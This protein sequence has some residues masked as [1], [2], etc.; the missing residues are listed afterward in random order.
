MAQTMTGVSRLL[1]KAGKMPFMVRDMDGVET[2]ANAVLADRIAPVIK[3]SSVTGEVCICLR[4]GVSS[5]VPPS[6]KFICADPY[7]Q[8][9]DCIRGLLASLK[10]R[11]AA[12]Y[13]SGLAS[14]DEAA[15]LVSGFRTKDETATT[16]TATTT[17]AA[18]AAPDAP[19]TATATATAPGTTGAGA[20]A[21]AGTSANE[22]GIPSWFDGVVFAVAD[23]GLRDAVGGGLK[24]GGLAFMQSRR[25]AVV[26]IQTAR[27]HPQ[28]V[29]VPPRLLRQRALQLHPRQ[30]LVCATYAGARIFPFFWLLHSSDLP[31]L[32]T[33]A[34]LCCRVASC[35]LGPHRQRVQRAGCRHGRRRHGRARRG[36]GG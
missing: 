25:V 5:H 24:S 20:G 1:R 33:H 12:A 13:G 30:R 31:P 6:P 34:T 27:L 22:C 32:L 23:A 26:A 19:A 2:A 10:P 29:R 11:A 35:G 7:L 15:A 3:C 21:A 4:S 18:A 17:T 28:R 14:L 16:A 9:V 36:A 8:G